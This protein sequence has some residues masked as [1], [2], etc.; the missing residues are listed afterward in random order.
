MLTGTVTDGEFSTLRTKGDGGKV[1]HVAELMRE[2]RSMVS[3]KAGSTLK[4]MLIKIGG[5]LKSKGPCC[6]IY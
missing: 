1:T 3:S 4:K 2:S 6:T 5:E